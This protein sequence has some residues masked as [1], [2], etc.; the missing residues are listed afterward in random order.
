MDEINKEKWVLV[1]RSKLLRIPIFHKQDKIWQLH[2]HFN[3]I[4]Q[5]SIRKN[6]RSI[7]K[8]LFDRHIMKLSYQLLRSNNKDSF[9]SISSASRKDIDSLYINGKSIK[10]WRKKILFKEIFLDNLDNGV[11]YLR[12]N[13]LIYP[14]KELWTY[15]NHIA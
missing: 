7:L 1:C 11:L 3:F 8:W 12:I 2:I 10:S 6:H 13:K 5:Q 15:F 9:E 4:E 14:I